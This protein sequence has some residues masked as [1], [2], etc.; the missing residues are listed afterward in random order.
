LFPF[1]TPFSEITY[2][3]KRQYF[4]D[5]L[6]KSNY[7]KNFID[8]ITYDDVDNIEVVG[9]LSEYPY[10]KNILKK[11]CNYKKISNNTLS[12]LNINTINFNRIIK[13]NIFIKYGS[14]RKCVYVE[15]DR[16]DNEDITV[17]DMN[18]DNFCVYINDLILYVDIKTEPKQL[19][20]HVAR[21]ISSNQSYRIE[22]RS[23][24]SFVPSISRT[25]LC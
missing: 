9:N 19:F 11:T 20:R 2:L 12:Y 8:C 1:D 13:H 22:D 6:E 15:N 14:T 17:I 18:G 7:D 3:Y 23:R 24:T 21:R 16:I 4:D 5:I 10:V 25:A